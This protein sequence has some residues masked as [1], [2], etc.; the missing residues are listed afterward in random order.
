MKELSKYQEEELVKVMQSIEHEEY[1]VGGWKSFNGGFAECELVEYKNDLVEFNL[2][3]GIQ[4]MGGGEQVHTE[5]MTIDIETL[6]NK[7]LTLD[8]KIALV[9]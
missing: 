6:A 9:Y 3:F 5:E 2:V 8:E 7:K 1:H 4:D